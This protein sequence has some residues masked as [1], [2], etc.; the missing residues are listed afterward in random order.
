MVT[1]TA[2]M[3]AIETE[4]KFRV[5]DI[6]QLERDLQRLG[7]RL[8]TPSAFERNTLYDTPERSLL[9]RHEILRLRSYGGRWVLTHKAVPPDYDPAE[10]YKQRVETETLVE[11]GDAIATIFERLGLRPVFVYE[12]WRTEWADVT[13]HCVIDA[14]AIGVFAELEGPVEWIDAACR[15]LRLAASEFTTMS[16][17]RLFEIW[18]SETGSDARDMTFDAIGVATPSPR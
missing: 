16:Y 13:G 18:K 6:A 17:G 2:A 9:V 11:D 5:T 7:F 4:V 8:L 10:R 15:G 12:K 3:T 1:Y 14:T